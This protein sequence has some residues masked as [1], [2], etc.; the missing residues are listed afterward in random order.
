MTN[1]LKESE[2]TVSEMPDNQLRVLAERYGSFDW[3]EKFEFGGY[4]Y[5]FKHQD[6]L[7]GSEGHYF[8]GCAIYQRRK[9]E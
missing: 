9:G 7:K 8:G 2:M 5:Y 4:T 1:V 3:P 6:F